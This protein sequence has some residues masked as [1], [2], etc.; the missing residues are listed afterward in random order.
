MYDNP[1]P[2]NDTT[3]E[4]CRSKIIPLL[5]MLHHAQDD[6]EMEVAPTL[7]SS[8]VVESEEM[9]VHSAVDE[10]LVTGNAARSQI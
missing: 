8:A 5:S 2:F 4:L 7:E 3:N 1:V 6:V 9:A 10:Q